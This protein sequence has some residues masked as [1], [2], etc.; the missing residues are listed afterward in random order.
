MQ[1]ASSGL[2][3]IKDAIRESARRVVGSA[4]DIRQG[5][6]EIGQRARPWA[7]KLFIV[8]ACIELLVVLLCA[9]V[10][11]AGHPGD[12]Y[13]AFL[14]VL[15][16][17][18]SCFLCYFAFD[19]VAHENT[20]QLVVFTVGCLLLTARMWLVFS[21]AVPEEALSI[22]VTTVAQVAY[23][24]LPLVMVQDFGRHIFYKVG[25]RLHIVSLYKRFQF[26][27]ALLK[28]DV[29]FS[30]VLMIVSMYYF[31][32]HYV[33]NV[34]S[35]VLF[36][37]T[38]LSSI[39]ALG[40]V[41]Q[42][43]RRPARYFL[44]GSLLQPLLYAIA[45]YRLNFVEGVRTGLDDEASEHEDV[46]GGMPFWNLT[47]WSAPDRAIVLINATAGLCLVIRL[48]MILSLAVVTWGFGKGLFE[49]L[50]Q[51]L[52][53]EPALAASGSMAPGWVRG[54]SSPP[55]SLP[56]AAKLQAAYPS[57]G[58][59]QTRPPALRETASAAAA[60][61][62]VITA[63]GDALTQALLSN[64]VPNVSMVSNPITA[65]SRCQTP[66]TPVVPATPPVAA[67]SG[68]GCETEIVF[69]E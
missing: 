3:C 9:V 69:A 47:T 22:V 40:W 21:L 46:S 38:L 14:W 19:A 63:D 39:L 7:H 12:R 62:S 66:V 59:V 58:D 28:A 60:S 67:A 17:C 10:S 42:E 35:A 52:E 53:S 68:F 33:M 48:I 5:Y 4:I 1:G 24:F 31:D 41:E 11:I 37:I 45:L 51:Q 15:S 55:A 26:W 16:F 32:L 49:V 6:S 30:L 61:C 64:T 2:A 18:G 36:G 44:V 8:V 57:M 43:Q 54:F 29:Q 25:G 34:F 56:P 13:D 20:V 27:L 23:L 65:A 50:H